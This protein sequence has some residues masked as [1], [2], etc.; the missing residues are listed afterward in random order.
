MA[1]L[2]YGYG[3]AGADGHLFTRPQRAGWIEPDRQFRLHGRALGS[4]LHRQCYVGDAQWRRTIQHYGEGCD[5][6]ADFFCTTRA[7]R[8]PGTPCFP[9][10]GGRKNVRGRAPWTVR[11]AVPS[12]RAGRP[13][14]APKQVP[15]RF[16]D[17]HTRYARSAACCVRGRW[18]RC[19]QY[20]P[21]NAG[22]DLHPDYHGNALRINSRA[23]QH[24]PHAAGELGGA[25]R[26]LLRR[27]GRWHIRP[28]QLM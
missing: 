22:G 8:A 2:T 12:G 13:E 27:N 3:L 11:I 5:H 21:G 16:G 17:C 15:V 18:G 7:A 25:W 9:P 28:D 10:S 14:A 1:R 23:T 6:G 24:H 19:G 4:H 20:E 26:R